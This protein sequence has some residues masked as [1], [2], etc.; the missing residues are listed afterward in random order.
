MGRQHSSIY[1]YI[2]IYILTMDLDTYLHFAVGVAREVEDL[3]ASGI[4]L[5][6]FGIKDAV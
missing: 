2:Y 3:G 4:K 6:F 1:I 5:T